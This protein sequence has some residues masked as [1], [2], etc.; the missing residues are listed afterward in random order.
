MALA[1]THLKRKFVIKEKGND[2]E[3]S[4]PNKNLSPEEV[5]K[6]YTPMY[7][8]LTNARVDGPKI[9]GSNAIYTLEASVGTKG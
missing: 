2:V 7:P 6:H 8:I 4:D 5:L 9:E 1:V 3:L